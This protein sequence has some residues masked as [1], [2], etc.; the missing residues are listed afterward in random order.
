VFQ[1]PPWPQVYK[2]KHLGMQTASTNIC[3]R[4]GRSQELSEFQ[5]GTVIGCHLCNK[6]RREIS[7]LQNIPQSAV[8]GIITKW[9]RLRMTATRPQSG[10]PGKMAERGQRM[11]RRILRRGCQ[12]S[13][14][15]VA[16]DLQTSCGLHI[17][18]RTVLREL[19]GMGFHGNCIQAIHHQVQCKAS[20]AVL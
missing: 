5:R 11:L 14:E 19:H 20:D 8:S 16:T 15:S 6:S 12:L 13:A 10:R 1:S 9:K 3:D 17:S 2:F 7:S 4:M 18:S